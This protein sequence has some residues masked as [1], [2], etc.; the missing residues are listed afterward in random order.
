MAGNYHVAMTDH[1]LKDWLTHRPIPVFKAVIFGD[2]EM[3]LILDNASYH[4]GFD[5]E[6]DVRESDS[7]KHNTELLHTFGVQEIKVRRKVARGRFISS[8]VSREEVAQAT[9]EYLITREHPEELFERAEALTQ[10]KGWELIG[11]PPI[12]TELSADR[13]FPAV[14]QAFR[15]LRLRG[16]AICGTRIWSGLGERGWLER[17]KIPTVG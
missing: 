6:V 3:I 1:T 4:H 13:S 5:L 10:A 17:R 7:K 8:G 16:K 11:N 14:R 2:K 12:H 9:R 15:Q